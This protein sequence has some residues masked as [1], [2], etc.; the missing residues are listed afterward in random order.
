[1]YVWWL[2]SVANEVEASP[3][4]LGHRQMLATELE[5]LLIYL[6][7]STRQLTEMPRVS[8]TSGGSDVLDSRSNQSG[9]AMLPSV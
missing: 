2:L 9:T 4:N 8:M 1:M 3:L 5:A 7:I 6:G